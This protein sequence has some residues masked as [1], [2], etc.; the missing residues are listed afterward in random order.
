[1]KLHEVAQMVSATSEWDQTIAEIEPAGFSIDSRTVQPGDVFFAVRGETLDGHQFVADA[2]NHGA[3]AAIV[4]EPMPEA[5]CIQVDDTLRALQT[6]AH[7]VRVQWNGPVIGV[8]GSSGKTM[9]KELTAQLLGAGGARVIKTMGNYNNA[10]GLPLSLLQLA[11]GG[12]TPADV[13][14][15]V[16]E[17]GMSAPGEIASLCSIAEPNVGIITN[18]SGVHLEFFP[19]VE[20]IAEAKAEMVDHVRDDG[21]VVLNLDDPL[22]ARMRFRRLVAVRTYGTES[23]ADVMATDI[24]LK[25]LMG[26]AFTLRT[27][28]G[29]VDVHSP[30]M[31]RHNIYNALAAAAAADFYEIPLERIADGLG[32]AAPYKMRGELIPFPQGFTVINDAYNSNPRAL[33]EMVA[34]LCATNSVG[35]RIVVAG[36]MLE[37]GPQGPEMH[38][39]CGREMA[40]HG[41]NV[42]IGVRGLA[43]EIVQGAREEAMDVASTIFCES[44]EAAARV[45]FENLKSG[46]L[47]LVKGSRGVKTERVIERLKQLTSE[48]C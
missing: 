41:V 4:S 2:L 27:P 44:P 23:T 12:G 47:V 24:Q 42:I 28:R 10:F 36:E 20:A 8:T 6:L 17:M 29:A 39:E 11:V 45:L 14:Y 46:D 40:R 31:G 26:S 15:V 16:L 43:Q 22:V 48:S 38:R 19:N 34:T 37:L 1:M 3:C 21:L 13:D 9:T 33:K 18:V 32:Q 7:T 5:R 25:G 30:L 35:R